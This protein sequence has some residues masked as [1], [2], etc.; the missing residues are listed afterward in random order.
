[1]YAPA[2]VRASSGS[3]HGSAKRPRCAAAQSQKREPDAPA[4]SA[5]E[6][7][8]SATVDEFMVGGSV[9]PCWYRPPIATWP[10]LFFV[11][12]GVVT[13]TAVL[14]HSEGI[15]SARKDVDVY[16]GSGPRAGIELMLGR[17]VLSRLYGDGLVSIKPAQARIGGMEVWRSAP[18][19]GDVGAAF[20]ALF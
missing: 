15:P 7:L 6:M 2:A 19:T 20:L 12:C 10:R 3:A 16:V 14:G 9:V 17:R 13:T 4:G 5:L 11:L 18:V 8:P 1:M